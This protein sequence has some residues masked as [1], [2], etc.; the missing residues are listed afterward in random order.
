MKREPDKNR[1]R[2]MENEKDRETFLQQQHSF[3]QCVKCF[4]R[5][6][7]H[8]LQCSKVIFSSNDFS[9]AHHLQHWDIHSG[10]D[11]EE[12]NHG[13]GVD[14]TTEIGN[15][16][17]D[18]PAVEELPMSSVICVNTVHTFTQTPKNLVSRRHVSIQTNI[19]VGVCTRDIQTQTDI[20]E[21]PTE[22]IDMEES[23]YS[24]TED[25]PSDQDW[26]P[27][28]FNESY[29]RDGNP[30]KE[31]KFI[32]Y[33]KCCSCG[34]SLKCKKKNGKGS[35]LAV[36]ALCECGEFLSWN[37]QPLSGTLPLGNLLT[38]A[39][40]LFAG[41]HPSQVLTM[42][43]HA[44]VQMICQRTY[45]NLQTLYLVPAISSVY[46]FKQLNLFEEIKE[47]GVA[48]RLGGDAR[49]CSPR[50]TAKYGSYSLIDL[51]KAKILDIQLVQSNKVK[52]SYS[53][54]LEGHS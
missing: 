26:T 28:I 7:I 29:V 3:K 11:L 31:R 16:C 5:R 46:Q 42:F 14:E 38:A 22:D 30:A 23:L 48:L 40:I 50:H 20:M 37:S 53:M 9:P 33:S 10:I 25:D 13:H 1:N 45:N 6:K 34:F 12:M 4:K 17:A 52:N 19:D 43:Q 35:F 44:S 51:T 21:M 32:L 36:K 15:Q 54:E 39:A 8:G 49:C 47:T 41:C 2:K 24:V 18:L 27:D